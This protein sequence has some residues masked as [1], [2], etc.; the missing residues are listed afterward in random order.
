MRQ[1]IKLISFKGKMKLC[2]NARNGDFACPKYSYKKLNKQKRFSI[3]D[4]TITR[5]D[6]SV[7]VSS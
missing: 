5:S 3:T 4:N 6:D 2:K 1:T 7:F